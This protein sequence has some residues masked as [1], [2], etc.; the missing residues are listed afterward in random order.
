MKEKKDF[1]RMIVKDGI[2]MLKLW[3]DIGKEMKLKRLKERRKRKLK[4]WKL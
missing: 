3:I 1:E 2:K 4:K